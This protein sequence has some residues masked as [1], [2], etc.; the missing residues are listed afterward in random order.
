M[1]RR[2]FVFYLYLFREVSLRACRMYK[3]K[4]II[5]KKH[6][7]T[8]A[9][10]TPVFTSAT[11]VW[12]SGRVAIPAPLFS[13]TMLSVFCGRSVWLYWAHLRVNI[14]TA[15][16]VSGHYLCYNG[17]L[18]TRETF[19]ILRT[20]DAIRRTEETTVIFYRQVNLRRRRWTGTKTT[21]MLGNT[22]AKVA[23][24]KLLSLGSF[25]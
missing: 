25:G 22:L 11:I 17:N 5:Q 16:P 2:I 6:R 8:L 20:D 14:H 9:T 10:F 18:E 3:Y 4:E 23:D 24:D 13:L 12:C 15:F 19:Y 1:V 7:S 21:V